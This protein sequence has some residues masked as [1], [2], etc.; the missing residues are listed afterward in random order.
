MSIKR[1]FVKIVN[2]YWLQEIFILLKTTTF[3][4][5]KRNQPMLISVIDKNRK[6]QGLTDRFKG[7]VSVFALSKALNVPFKCDFVQPFQL[8]EFLIPNNYNWLP[9]S[10]E[11]SL[12]RSEVRYR[13]LRK[14]PTIKKI[15]NVLP[16][17]KQ[18]RVYANVD[19]LDEINK[20]FNKNYQWGELFNELFKTTEPVTE[21]LNFYSKKLPEGKFIA[22]VFRFQTLL[23]DF[24]EY[25]Y[26]SLSFLEREELI[27]KN[28]NSL[29]K[30]VAAT[31]CPVLVTSDSVGFL[32][33]VSKMEDV[34]TIPGKVV[35]MD[36]VLDEQ[37]EVYLKSFV[38]FFMLSK[39]ERVYSIGTK[40]MYPTN[41]PVYAAKIKNVPFERILIE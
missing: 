1:F 8:S 25:K 27:E 6:S 20:R 41:F 26:K 28:I 21:Q 14:E 10:N 7:I 38:D 16:L 3:S 23:G 18:I 5:D 34:F 39:A 36:C 2:A 19:Y 32:E 40:I 29:K 33:I 9:E 37:N 22:C 11:L 15:L 30:I 35:H 4:A 17:K 31:N 13:I 12:N 24:E